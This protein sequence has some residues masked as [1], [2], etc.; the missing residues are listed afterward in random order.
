MATKC[1]C[2]VGPGKFEGESCMTFMAYQQM[3]LGNSDLSVGRYD[4]F[5]A[6]FLFD[7][8]QEVVKAAKGYGYC[9]ACIEERSESYGY[10]IWESAQ[11]FAYGRDLVTKDEYEGAIKTAEE[12]E[13]ESD[14]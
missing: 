10:V 3:C 11:G 4:F 9:E 7:A 1:M 8:D 6:P 5:K 2:N 12:E 13:G 14:E